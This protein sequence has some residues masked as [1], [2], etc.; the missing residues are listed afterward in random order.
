M[1]I[2]MLTIII[3]IIIIIIII[4]HPINEL[5]ARETKEN[6]NEKG[7]TSSVPVLHNIYKCFFLVIRI[8]KNVFFR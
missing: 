3:D 5:P 6:I 1:M 8:K 2:I 7:N 4:V